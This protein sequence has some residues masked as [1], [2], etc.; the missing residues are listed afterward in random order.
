MAISKILFSTQHLAYF[1]CSSCFESSKPVTCRSAWLNLSTSSELAGKLLQW[2][3]DKLHRLH[4]LWRGTNSHKPRVKNLLTPGRIYAFGCT[5][6]R[7]PFI[8]RASRS[9][10]VGEKRF[11]FNKGQRY[12]QTS[13]SPLSDTVFR[14]AITSTLK[15]VP[16]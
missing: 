15:F 3:H 10:A 5:C 14:I 2:Q 8:P 7:L 12:K 9:G 11:D 6:W 13:D 1:S 4:A 16:L